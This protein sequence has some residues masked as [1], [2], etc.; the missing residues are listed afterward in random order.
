MAPYI[1]QLPPNARMLDGGCGL[2]EWTVNLSRVGYHVLGLDISEETVTRLQKAFPGAIFERGD[3]RDTGQPDDSFEAYFSWGTFEHFEEGMQSCTNEAFSIIRP[4]GY[5]F[6]SVPFENL[7]VQRSSGSYDADQESQENRR[8][9]FYQW[10]LTK[11]ELHD[12]LM[13]SGFQVLEIRSIHKRQGAVRVLNQEFGLPWHWLFTRVLSM[14][15][16]PFLSADI[17]AHMLIA[18]A[19]KP[20]TPL[21]ATIVIE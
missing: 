9:R 20:S 3:I 1:R 5:L 8:W 11:A 13:Q 2:G 17:F 10:R 14:I 16:A 7:P 21:R 12:Q 4:G 19:R 15:L 18:V 6:T